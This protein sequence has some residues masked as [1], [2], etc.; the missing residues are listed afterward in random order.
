MINKTENFSSMKY[1]SE[2]KTI[3]FLE[4]LLP[5]IYRECSIFVTINDKVSLFTHAAFDCFFK[6]QCARRFRKKR[7]SSN[8]LQK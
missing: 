4:Q 1:L 8:I 7:G 3:L 6:K 5:K 2:F